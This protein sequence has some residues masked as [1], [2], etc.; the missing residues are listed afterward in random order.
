M[1]RPLLDCMHVPEDE[2]ELTDAVPEAPSPGRV[3]FSQLAMVIL[4]AAGVYAM[5]RGAAQ[6]P[7]TVDESQKLQG[8]LAQSNS[9]LGSA[10]GGSDAAAADWTNSV[11]LWR[12]KSSERYAVV[13]LHLLGC[14]GLLTL[15]PASVLAAAVV[16]WR[17]QFPR[18]AGARLSLDGV[19]IALNVAVLLLL[20]GLRIFDSATLSVMGKTPT[21]PDL[22]AFLKTPTKEQL[23][24][25]FAEMK[26]NMEQ[27]IKDLAVPD[28]RKGATLVRANAARAVG[29]YAWNKE[30]VATLTEAEKDTFRNALKAAV[31]KVYTD[32]DAAPFIIRAIGPLGD[33][34]AASALE[35]EREKTR[36][37]WVD[38]ARPA[39]LKFLHDSVAAG[40][41]ADVRKL[42]ERGVNVN[43]YAPGE[44][45]TALHE[46]VARRQVRVAELL[47]E[48]GAKVDVAGKYARAYVEREFPLHRAAAVGDV[49]LVKLLLDKGADPMALDYRGMT[50]LHAASAAGEV[51]TAELLLKRKAKVNQLDFSRQTPLDSCNNS[52]SFQQKKMRDLL[53]QAGGLSAAQ[54]LGKNAEASIAPGR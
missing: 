13:R 41:E 32:D 28:N 15:F 20:A 21:V 6:Y 50:P 43:A 1:N 30:F 16:W 18:R 25:Q 34:N 8:Y 10:V 4:L 9:S 47:L 26:H 31:K 11:R 17:G 53:A 39:G 40:R 35:A 46:A 29:T 48:K 51:E 49:K 45:H 3:W 33:V 22:Q 5:L 37:Q 7:E 12:D 36:A 44:G 14:Y 54:L 52:P 38:V 27:A 19:Q 2:K 23:V 42:I 24:E